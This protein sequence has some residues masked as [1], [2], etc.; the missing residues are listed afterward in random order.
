[1]VDTVYNVKYK[2]LLYTV[3]IVYDGYV[4]SWLRQMH[5]FTHK[6]RI[7]EEHPLARLRTHTQQTNGQ[8][9]KQTQ[10]QQSMLTIWPDP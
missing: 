8:T 9:G 7:T 6:K 1:M 3:Y 4:F 10:Q 5:T 2:R